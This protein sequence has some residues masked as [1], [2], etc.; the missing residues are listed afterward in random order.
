[1]KPVCF[2]FT[3]IPEVL[4]RAAARYLGPVTVYQ[5]IPGRSSSQLNQ[6]RDDG[7]AVIKTAVAG[8][9]ETLDALVRDYR[10]W[11]ELHSGGGV[12]FYRAHK[13]WIP[14]FDENSLSG[15]R[16]Q[17]LRKNRQEP[18]QTPAEADPLIH[19]AVFLQI[20]REFDI[21]NRE[22]NQGVLDISK[23]E[24]DLME[25]IQ[26]E[27]AGE[28]EEENRYQWDDPGAFMTE[29]RLS[30]WARLFLNDPV[31]C[32]IL[33]TFGNAIKDFL[34]DRL[35]DM[36]SIYMLESTP[37]PEDAG[38]RTGFGDSE[39]TPFIEAIMDKD[40]VEPPEIPAGVPDAESPALSLEIFKI[41]GASPYQSVR[42]FLNTADS[43][44][45]NPYTT[46]PKNTLIACF[47]VEI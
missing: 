10:K 44:A 6:L 43:P 19:A 22:I 16:S 45:H 40:G 30:A 21:Q 31:P 20:A 47:T 14:G 34:T 4:C 42:R 24:K 27:A 35:E 28:S 39:L 9:A 38:S 17:I 29:E 11:V 12:D 23:L 13:E 46:E 15:I 1:M 41:Q 33:V 5:P 3:D 26:G 25:T 32:D 7:Y 8:D 37:F 36:R 2:P 18:D